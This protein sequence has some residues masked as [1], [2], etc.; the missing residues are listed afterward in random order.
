MM[1]HTQDSYVDSLLA[2]LDAHPKIDSQYI[3]TL[4]RVS[5]RLS[6]SDVKKSFAYYERVSFLSDSMNFLFG[7]SLAQIN[8]GILLYNSGDFDASNSAYFKAIDLADSCHGLRLKAVSYN[9][10]GENFKILRDYD[11]C[12]KY[13][14]E[15]IA[16]N[17]PLH[18]NRGVAINYELLHEC[19]LQEKLYNESRNYLLEGLPYA[20]KADENYILSQYYVGF[21]KLQ[22]IDNRTDSA[23]F[24]F[25][26]AMNAA[27]EEGDLRNEF[28]AY[29]A[30]AR[31][32]KN[33]N[34]GKRIKLC[35][36]QLWTLRK[37]LSTWKECPTRLRNC[38]QCM[39]RKRTR[40]PLCFSTVFIDPRQIRCFQRVTSAM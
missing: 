36:I 24:Y 40:I 8:L 31:Y 26:K 38:H 15:A 34:T 9:N 6:E 33:L 5:Y 3:Q 35:W 30:E 19:A 10:I 21:G 14:R 18:A 28:Q 4:H 27:K 11:K 25:S 20:L 37:T 17:K 39:M 29:L 22:A 32:L 13:A 7:R 16:I 23:S 2:W 12:R 1:A